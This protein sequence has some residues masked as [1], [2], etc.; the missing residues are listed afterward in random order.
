MTEYQY[1]MLREK[2]ELMNMAAED[3]QAKGIPPAW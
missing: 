1:I 2:P 3:L